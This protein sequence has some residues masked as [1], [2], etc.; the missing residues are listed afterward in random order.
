MITEVNPK[1]NSERLQES[2]FS[3]AGYNIYSVNI[4]TLVRRGIIIYVDERLKSCEINVASDFSEFLI[5][6]IYMAN[7][8]TLHLGALYRSPSI[9]IN[10][11]DNLLNLVLDTISKSSRDDII[12]IGDF[13]NKNID[14]LNHVAYTQSTV[15]ERK[16][17]SNLQDNLLT[18]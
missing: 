6:K 1:V 8:K 3:L 5:V 11:D 12:M 14:W 10:N 18:Q 16:F 4:G 7:D 9:C 13:N 15:S 2:E 17:V